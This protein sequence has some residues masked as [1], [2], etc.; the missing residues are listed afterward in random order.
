MTNILLINE[1]KQNRTIMA[2]AL[3]HGGHKVMVA[4]DG[5]IMLTLS[6]T[7]DIDLIIFDVFSSAMD[8]LA[9]MVK[10]NERY[11]HIRLVASSRSRW[12]LETALALGASA[13]LLKPASIIEVAAT[14]DI[15]LSG[16]G[17]QMSRT[18]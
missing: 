11:P 13:T 18:A 8:G 6:H 5:D 15:A 3:R 1:D 2:A 9:T 12:H 17:V 10:V 7:T 4:S 16:L 14:V